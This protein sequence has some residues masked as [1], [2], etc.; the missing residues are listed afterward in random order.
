MAAGE[1]SEMI[2]SLVFGGTKVR[3]RSDAT[4]GGCTKVR[5][6]LEEGMV[7]WILSLSFKG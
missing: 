2:P 4:K 3:E 5:K 7:A 6:E 1:S